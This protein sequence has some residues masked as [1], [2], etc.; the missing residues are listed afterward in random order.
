MP[1]IASDEDNFCCRTE[2]LIGLDGMQ[3]LAGK[4][5]LIAGLGGVGGHAAEAFARAGI[6]RLTIIDHDVV[7]RANL[8][9]QLLALRSTI[10]RP[11]TEVMRERLLDIN[12][13]LQIEAHNAFIDQNNA[14]DFIAGHEL[15][16]VADCIDS[17]AC[18]AALV[19]ACLQHEVPVMSC[20]GA[21][22]RMDPSRIRITRLNQTH[23]DGLARAL[24]N[25]LKQMG[26]RPLLKVVF[27]DEVPSEPRLLPNAE[28][29]QA[30]RPNTI[31]GTI[32][33]M[34]AMFGLTLAGA[35]IRRLLDTP[36]EAA[37]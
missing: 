32:S 31:N 4:H 15:D 21:G 19:A 12:P 18:K 6:G 16:F 35:I 26:L 24:R 20:M 30:A 33:Y 7:D 23:G 14:V 36:P 3:T 28:P 10:G 29:D 11:K 9:R 2:V 17:V 5:V 1:E 25:R 37:A 27:S 13:C 8:N 34:P 22:N